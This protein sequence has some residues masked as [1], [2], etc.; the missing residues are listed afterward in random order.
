VSYRDTTDFEASEWTNRNREL[1]NN[2]DWEKRESIGAKAWRQECSGT[3]VRRMFDRSVS[4]C[5]WGVM[6]LKVQ[7]RCRS[8]S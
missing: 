6:S 4:F 7:S 5:Q 8:M 1:L 3:G 2:G